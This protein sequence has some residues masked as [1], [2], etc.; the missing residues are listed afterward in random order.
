MS[1][2]EILEDYNSESGL[3][4]IVYDYGDVSEK[5]VKAVDGKVLFVDYV[6]YLEDGTIFSQSSDQGRQFQFKL[7]KG[8][9][10]PAWDE[11]FKNR[12]AGAEMPFVVPP[13][14]AYG[15]AGS[16]DGSIPPDSIIIFDV[17]L[18]GVEY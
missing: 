13:H 8:Q 10:I 11:G 6:G 17:K 9:V 14:L 1:K 3:S 12:W 18:R 7:G 15:D 16:R 4:V 2:K 5:G